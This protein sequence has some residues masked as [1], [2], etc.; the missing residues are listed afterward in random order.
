[1]SR[2]RDL[3]RRV[4]LVPMDPHC[5]NITLALYRQQETD[6]PEYTVLKYQILIVKLST[7]N[8]NQTPSNGLSAGGW[9][10]TSWFG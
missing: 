6:G 4:E 2:T 10:W 1:M 8:R 3:G 5:R 9:P 7:V